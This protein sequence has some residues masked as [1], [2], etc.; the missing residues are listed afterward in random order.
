MKPGYTRAD[1][2][3]CPEFHIYANAIR[4]SF[5]AAVSAGP[6]LIIV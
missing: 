2:C 1:M 5:S 6:T 3:V 4:I